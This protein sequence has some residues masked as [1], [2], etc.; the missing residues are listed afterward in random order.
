M[1]QNLSFLGLNQ[2]YKQ[3]S[4]F[5]LS[6][7]AQWAATPKP[8]RQSRD[9]RL[10]GIEYSWDLWGF[11]TPT[12]FNPIFATFW[13]TAKT[14]AVFHG[15]S[16]GGPNAK[17]LIS[18]CGRPTHGQ[19]LGRIGHLQYIKWYSSI[20]SP[21]D[22]PWAIM[23]LPSSS[24][25]ISIFQVRSKWLNTLISPILTIFGHEVSPREKLGNPKIFGSRTPRGGV[26]GFSKFCDFWVPPTFEWP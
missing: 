25:H 23:A 4:S 24:S 11:K 16:K 6:N 19:L 20:E 3:I 9:G 8:V 7:N 22:T 13:S 2:I 14:T 17:I 26:M 5:N 15:V 18:L 10:Y 12:K 1:G 21:L